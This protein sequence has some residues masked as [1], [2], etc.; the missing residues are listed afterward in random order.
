MLCN[1]CHK[2]IPAGEEL[3]EQDRG[4]SYLSLYEGTGGGEGSFIGGGYYHRL[5]YWHKILWNLKRER[6]KLWGW[7][8]LWIFLWPILIIIVIMKKNRANKLDKAIREIEEIISR[9]END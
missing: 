6:D 5:C 4:Y 9:E 3:K 8:W 7:F 1:W 2:V